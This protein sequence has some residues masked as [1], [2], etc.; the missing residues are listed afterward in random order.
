VC[1]DPIIASTH[2]QGSAG[3]D[4]CLAAL[5]VLKTWH[6]PLLS[7]IVTDCLMRFPKLL[8][9]NKGQASRSS[10]YLSLQLIRSTCEIV[11]AHA[12]GWGLLA[13]HSLRNALSGL[14]EL[15]R[16]PGQ[17]KRHT[18]VWVTFCSVSCSNWS[19]AD[20][21]CLPLDEAEMAKE[22][23][24]EERR[25]AREGLNRLPLYQ[26]L[27]EI[28]YTTYGKYRGRESHSTPAAA[29]GD[30]SAVPG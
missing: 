25:K 6:S 29:V 26:K 12:L 30:D 3:L 7:P 8:I 15:T 11:R 19:Q 2:S 16:F 4:A 1:L 14:D 18:V 17:L 21:A 10:G 20:L 28:L 5:S 22:P 23:N 24:R 27:A 9:S 13:P